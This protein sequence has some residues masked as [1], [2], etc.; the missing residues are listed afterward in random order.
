MLQKVS[1]LLIILFFNFAQAQK[2]S[3]NGIILDGDNM[4]IEYA[5]ISA[6]K[7]TKAVLS[8][9][10]GKFSLEIDKSSQFLLIKLLGYREKKINI[11]ST[12]SYTIN[13]ETDSKNIDQVVIKLNN[14]R[15]EE[16]G[17]TTIDP[18]NAILLPTAFGDFNKL[19][20][21]LP[22][23]TSNNELSSTY[24]VR[25]GNY[26]EN[27]IYVNGIEVYRPFLVSSGQ[28]EGLSFVNPN[29][30]ADVAFSS[31]GWQ[32]KFGD[33]LSSIMNV[34]YKEPKKFEG[35]AQFGLLGGTIHIG[36]SDKQNRVSAI[37]GFRNKSSRYLLNQLPVKG[38]YFPT[39][40]DFQSYVNI[41][42]T[43]R[44]KGFAIKKR[45][46]LGMLGSFAGNTYLVIP[47][48]QETSFGTNAE[49]LK[50]TVGFDGT[51]KMNYDTWQGGLK[52]SHWISTKFRTE[53]YASGMDSREREYI[54]LEAGYNL[55]EV[56]LDP[57]G[58]NDPNYKA[59]V[60]GVGT[61]FNYARNSLHA[62][63]LAAE[64]RSYYFRSPKNTIEF[65]AKYSKEI[66]DDKLSAYGFVDS[67]DFVRLTPNYINT[68]INL[69]TNRATAYLQSTHRIDTSHTLTFGVRTGWWDLNQQVLI[70][71]TLQYSY[72]PLWKKNYIFKFATGIYRQPPFYRELRNFEGKIN[73]NL[74]AQS[75]V[76]IL[77]GAD[78]KFLIWKRAFK[79]TSELYLKYLWDVV[80]Y[81]VDNVRLRYYGVNSAIAYATGLDMRIGGE[82]VKGSES[83][84]SM[85]I[86]QTKE[87]VDESV[88]GWIRR[89][90]DQRI[91]FN[92]FFQDQ[93]A[94]IPAWKIYINLV[95][96]TGLA[97][98]VPNSANFRNVFNIPPY[99]RLDL[100]TNYVITFNNKLKS[101]KFFE[102]IMLGIECLNVLEI[103]NVISYIWVADFQNRQY[104]VPN[105][106]STRFWNAKIIA[107][108]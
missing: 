61:I 43:N 84:F 1:I 63:V 50:L 87:K 26:D 96:G 59:T 45:T 25:G 21:M 51:E 29:L 60:R 41:D 85:S 94:K 38:Q 105:T 72:Q 20:Q 108:F 28:Q 11:D 65:G 92:V 62:T 53:F 76:H 70:S 67:L 93:I 35:S 82:F 68:T 100:G 39:F 64:N 106:L 79:F 15:R 98:G 31:G 54:N 27:L 33:K 12:N 4:P 7:S 97:F 75:S 46:T 101:K 23:V 5:V 74:K 17:M 88:Q 44:K 14:E 6:D 71:P 3:L 83:W 16:A 95:F 103:N 24:S 40:N 90:T 107:N 91:N 30:A 49:V 104:A 22:G 18:K 47:E 86:M 48:T 8:D 19:I 13:L 2:R 69:N 81:D 52:F 37:A 77:A 56:N 78:Y 32:S 89:P 34:N 10:L 66:I 58:K 57:S 99:R 55:S 73:P 80:P 36:G 9:E 102:T 42:L